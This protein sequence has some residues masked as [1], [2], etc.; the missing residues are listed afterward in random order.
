VTR[1]LA[2]PAPVAARWPLRTEHIVLIAAAV[3]LA[4]LVVLPLASLVWG[5]VSSEGRLTLEHF[6]EALS[7]RLYVQ[8]LAN[9]LVLGAWTAGLSVLLSLPMA[10]AVGSDP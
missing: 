4:V 8:A 2:T 5:S 9:S 10:W 3:A 7:R 1:V 6:R